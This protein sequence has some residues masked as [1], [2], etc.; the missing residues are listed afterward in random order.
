[1]GIVG[2]K[3]ENGDLRRGFYGGGRDDLVGMREYF[4][5]DG[6]IDE[7]IVVV[8]DMLEK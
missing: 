6:K 7:A 3:W 4:V 2:V 8:G 5:N 1:M